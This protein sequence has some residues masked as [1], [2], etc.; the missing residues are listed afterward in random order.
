[1]SRKV[2]NVGLLTHSSLFAMLYFRIL[3][4]RRS[5]RSL[6]VISSVPRTRRIH[7]FLEHEYYHRDCPWLH[8]RY[9][10]KGCLFSRDSLRETSCSFS[11]IC[12]YCHPIGVSCPQIRSSSQTVYTV[13]SSDLLISGP[14]SEDCLILNIWAPVIAMMRV[15]LKSSQSS[16]SQSQ[17]IDASTMETSRNNSPRPWE[18]SYPSSELPLIF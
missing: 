10:T 13:D 9:N 17:P 1:M 4:G 15:V 11:S 7:H 2:R 8:R 12:S 18:G 3:G 6:L 14:T 5:L 16:R